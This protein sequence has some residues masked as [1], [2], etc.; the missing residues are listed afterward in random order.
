M[1]LI[2]IHIVININIILT[3]ILILILIL[4]ILLLTGLEPPNHRRAP[5]LEQEFP[6]DHIG[7]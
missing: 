7:G 2:P 4:I 1:I 5:G 3:L 6:V